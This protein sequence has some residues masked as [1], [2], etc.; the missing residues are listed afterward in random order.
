MDPDFRRDDSALHTDRRTDG[1]PAPRPGLRRMAL[2]PVRWPPAS[3][4]RA[5][6]SRTWSEA[7]DDNVGFLAAGIAFYA[8]LAFVPLLASVVLVYGL[9]AD[10]RTVAEHIGKLFASLPRDAAGGVAGSIK[11]PSPRPQTGQGVGP[12]A[13]RPP[14]PPRPR[15]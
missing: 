13:A 11:S 10:P 12:A 14:P 15:Q 6:L 3:E 5:V 4:W 8:F 7:S 2:E 1:T 9:A